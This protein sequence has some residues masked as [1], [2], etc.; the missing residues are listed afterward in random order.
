MC[1]LVAHWIYLLQFHGIDCPV[2]DQ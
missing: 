1:H 2:D